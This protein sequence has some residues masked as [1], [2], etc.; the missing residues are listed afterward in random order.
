M[1][2]M[3]SRTMGWS[4]AMM[5]VIGCGSILVLLSHLNRWSPVHP[6][7]LCT[8]AGQ[9]LAAWWCVGGDVCVCCEGAV[10]YGADKRVELAQLFR[11]EVSLFKL[12]HDLTQRVP[13]VGIWRQCVV[14]A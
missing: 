10:D 14:S 12:V 2:R 1:A 6:S 3:P 4:S 8:Y 7:L 9:I 5:T 11:R 13:F